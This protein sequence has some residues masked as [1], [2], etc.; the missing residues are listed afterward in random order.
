MISL[1][2]SLLVFSP[3][4]ATQTPGRHKI[5]GHHTAAM[6]RCPDLGEVEQ[7][8]RF[9]IAVSLPW[10]AQDDLNQLLKDLYDPHSPNFHR[11]LTPEEFT[12]RYGPTE[13]DAQAVAD[14]MTGHGLKVTKV[15][16]N[17]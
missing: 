12:A 15:H 10:R 1:V 4:H 9:H 6:A 14:Y 3:A 11:F 2:F 7:G 5:F 16:G 13:A 17:R 8:H